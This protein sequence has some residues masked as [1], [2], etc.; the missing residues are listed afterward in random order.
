MPMDRRKISI[1]FDEGEID[2]IRAHSGLGTFYQSIFK[3]A[4]AELDDDPRSIRAGI[5]LVV[6]GCFWVEALCNERLKGI[7]RESV[8]NTGLARAFWHSVERQSSL[9][10]IRLMGRVSDGVADTR[11]DDVI[12]RL[13]P[14]YDLQNRLA[15]YKPDEAVIEGSVELDEMPEYVMELPESKLYPELVH[16]KTD[17]HVKAITEARN[18][19]I[20]LWEDVLGVRPFTEEEWEKLTDQ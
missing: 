13:K 15:H 20:T 4:K 18:L 5:K 14:T 17:K 2:S 19:I 10:K 7:I 12:R 6:F 9:E 11:I 16:P 3:K 1:S 8:D